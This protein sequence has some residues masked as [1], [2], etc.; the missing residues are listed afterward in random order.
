MLYCNLIKSPRAAANSRGDGNA[1][2]SRQRREVYHISGWAWLLLRP[3]CFFILDRNDQLFMITRVL[4]LKD[5]VAF[6]RQA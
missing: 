4:P 6:P 5:V 3:T 2:E 1:V